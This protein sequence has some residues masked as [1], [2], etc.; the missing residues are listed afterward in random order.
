MKQLV[1]I[2]ILVIINTDNFKSH[3]YKAKLLG[4][5]ETQPAPN[6]ANRILKKC[7]SSCAN[8]IFK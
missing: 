1:L 6:N 7:N 5:T 3:K 2:I 8:K 4:N